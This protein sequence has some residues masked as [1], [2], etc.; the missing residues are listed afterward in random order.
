MH[1]VQWLVG[2]IDRI[3]HWGDGLEAAGV[4]FR[5]ILVVIA[6]VLLVRAAFQVADSARRARSEGQGSVVVPRLQRDEGWSWRRAEELAARGAYA[7]AMLAA[8]TGAMQALDR[9]GLVRYRASA[10]PRELLVRATLPADTRATLEPLVATLY[11]A[12]FAAEPV[13]PESF[14]VWI[15]ALRGVVDAPAR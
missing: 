13:A 5:G 6:V 1:A 2:L 12:V 11:R 15:R 9:R 8:F 7:A 3:R 10:T 4:P 14:A